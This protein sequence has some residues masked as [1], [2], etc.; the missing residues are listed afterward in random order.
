MKPLF[1]RG[2]TLPPRNCKLA[3]QPPPP[4]TID[5]V[6]I[7][8]NEDSM[9]FEAPSN[10]IERSNTILITLEAEYGAV[11]IYTNNGTTYYKVIGSGVGK[12]TNEIENGETNPIWKK[13]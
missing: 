10:S 7:K 9:E 3:G 4:I 11:I 8:I 12:T 2:D 5:G 6:D 1:P 13:I